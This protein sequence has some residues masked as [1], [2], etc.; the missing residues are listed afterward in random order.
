M[1]H[2]KSKRAKYSLFAILLMLVN[3]KTM[4]TVLKTWLIFSF[5]QLSVTTINSGLQ[6]QHLLS[7]SE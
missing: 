4:A 5:T 6:H 2:T 1:V 3:V 7:I